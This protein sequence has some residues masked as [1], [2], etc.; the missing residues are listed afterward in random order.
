MRTILGIILFYGR[1]GLSFTSIGYHFRKLF[2]SAIPDTLQGKHVV[3]TGASGGIGAA[4]VEGCLAAGAEVTAVARN[5]DKLAA[6]NAGMPR[7]AATETVDLAEAA[8][9]D[10]LVSRLK[11]SGRTVDI[12]VNNV[13]VMLN[14]FQRNSAGIDKQFATNLLNQYRL[15]EALMRESLLAEDATV[16]T[17]ASGGMYMAPLVIAGLNTEEATAHDGTR[18]YAIQKRAQVVLTDHWQRE[19]SNESRR[20]YV[21]HPGWVDT[22]GVRDSLPTFRKLLAPVLRDAAQGADTIIWL[23]AARPEP[24]E[25]QSIWFDRKARKTHAYGFTRDRSESADA[26]IKHLTRLLP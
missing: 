12:L 11:A 8:D 14:E 5:A 2:W 13:G 24:G 22:A 26:L 3:V 6:M 1:F 19:S 21:V 17:V 7:T 10:A 16:I 15:T 25:E 9:I 4:V 18:A 23:A 20:F